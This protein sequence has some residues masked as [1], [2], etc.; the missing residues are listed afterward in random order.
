MNRKN[1]NIIVTGGS[2]FIGTNLILALLQNKNN[3]VLNIDNL[4]YASNKSSTFKKFLNYSFVKEK[5]IFKNKIKEII[6]KFKPNI[7]FHLAAETHVDRSIKK[8]NIFVNTNIIGTYSM[9]ESFNEYISLKNK[10]KGINYKFIYI[11]T[12]EVYGD[13]IKY[14]KYRSLEEDTILPSSPYSSS[15]ASGEMII[16]SW[17][18]TFNFPSIICRPSNNYG[19]FQN[20]EK[21]IPLVISSF[22]KNK[23]I[24]V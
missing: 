14:K 20:K 3:K 4:T 6:I 24:P 12:D 22:L 8:S 19:P 17:R 11:S 7:I 18:R 15:K 9:I 2:G 21:L 5:I 1:N 23:Q 13:I 10:L 16:N